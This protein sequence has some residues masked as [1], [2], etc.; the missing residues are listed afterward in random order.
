MKL[1]I[2]TFLAQYREFTTIMRVATRPSSE[3]STQRT[4]I[5]SK[6]TTWCLSPGHVGSK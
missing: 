4:A 1:W 3:G 6:K 5:D 2:K